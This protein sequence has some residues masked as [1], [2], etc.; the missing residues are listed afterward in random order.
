MCFD[1]KKRC[2]LQHST[3]IKDHIRREQRLQ[4]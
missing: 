2:R 1:K 3:I 4:Y